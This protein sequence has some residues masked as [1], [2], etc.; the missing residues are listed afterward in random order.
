[1]DIKLNN[2]MKK[3]FIIILGIFLFSCKSFQKKPVSNFEEE[4]FILA[5]KKCVLYG[6]INEATNNNLTLFSKENKDL[7]TAIEVE[8][9]QLQEALDAINK[10]KELSKKIKEINYADFEDKKPIFS[11]CVTFAFSKETDSIA[12]I[13]F[14]YKEM[15]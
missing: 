10:G 8:I 7:G 15:N 13:L 6:C 2:P 12:R 5:Y 3:L 14:K 9:I 11:T 4:E 1:M